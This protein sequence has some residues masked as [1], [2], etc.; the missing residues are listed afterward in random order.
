MMTFYM[1]PGSC[2]TGIHLLLEELEL[3]FQV[4][5]VNLL[6]GDQNTPEYLAINPKGTIPTLVTD[7]GQAL[8]SFESIAFWLAHQYPKRQLL[9]DSSMQQ[10]KILDVLSYCVHRIH[11]QGFTRI[12]TSPRYCIGDNDLER[13]QHEIKRMGEDII[14][15]GFEWVSQQLESNWIMDHFTIADAA[16]FYNEFW[17]IRSDIELPPPCV[18]HYQ[19]MIQRPAVRT[20]LA[21]EGYR[22]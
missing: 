2:S 15:Q 18:D 17:A 8:T 6:K 14:R 19:A 9:A 12:F 5:L 4:H 3:V 20:V 22:V 7:E 13:Q 1:T 11:G 21:E 10:A 16:L